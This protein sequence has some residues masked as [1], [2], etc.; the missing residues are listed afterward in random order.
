[1]KIKVL[2][3]FF[4]FTTASLFSQQNGGDGQKIVGDSGQAAVDVSKKADD[5]NKNFFK[6]NREELRN[7]MPER[8]VALVFSGIEKVRSNDVNFP[9]H[10]DPDFYYL[11]GF[12]EPDAL[13]ILFKEPYEIDNDMVTE[14]IFVPGKSKEYEM[15]HGYRMGTAGVKNELGFSHAFTNTE[16]PDF[17]IRFELFDKI[18]YNIKEG[19]LCDDPNYR[20]DIASLMKHF[21]FQTDSLKRRLDDQMLSSKLAVLR[22]IKKELEIEKLRKAIDITCLSH[23]ELMK[24]IDTSFAEYKAQ[25]LIEYV[26]RSNGGDGPGFPSIVGGGA[27]TCVLHYTANNSNLKDGDL[28]VVDIGAQYEHYSADVTRTIPVNGKFSEEQRLIYELVLRAQNAGIAKCVPGNKFWDPHD[29]ATEVIQKGLK[30]LGIIKKEYES[31]KYFMHGTSH[32][33]G[34]D[35]HDAGSYQPLRVNNLITVE[36]GIYIPEGSDCDKK[37]WNIGIRIEDDILITTQGPQNLSDCTP[38]E[39]ADIEALMAQ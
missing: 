9:F 31:K 15:W 35:V 16:F 13:L 39:I 7:L 29:A 2:I 33:L 21:L 12:N 8:S 3:L 6:K 38:R 5:A 19:V 28:L 1:M 26:F 4:L 11:T 18:L 22:E 34:L 37:W 14:I 36:P 10:Q 25:A 24:Q 32:Y 27:N 20:G 30:S 17:K 23:S